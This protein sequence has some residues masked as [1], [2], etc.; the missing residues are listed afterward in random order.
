MQRRRR[1]A[2]R[3]LALTGAALIGLAAIVGLSVQCSPMGGAVP[4]L[5]DVGLELPELAKAAPVP[6]APPPALGKTLADVLA[7][8]AVCTT[9]AVRPLS[10]QIIAEANC[11]RPATYVHVDAGPRAT[12]GDAVFP[13]LVESARDALVGALAGKKRDRLTV[14]SMLRTVAQQ[15][16]LYGWY[17]AGRCG[18][19]LA[20]EPGRSNH[21]SGLAIDVSNPGAWRTALT[22]RG[23]RW[24]GKKDRWHFDF[25]GRKQAE[26][27]ATKRLAQELAGLDV[28]AFQ[29]L[30]NNN[31]GVPK[32]DETGELD[33][34]TREALAA[35]PTLGFAV[36]ASCAA[37]ASGPASPPAP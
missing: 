10:E 24:L 30:H 11:I 35:A 26:K 3:G 14:S 9:D 31:G 37:P 12:F 23:F 13:Y 8:D 36:G 15:Y 28:R 29:R 19:K 20:A 32:L 18:I 1:I 4:E 5:R 27:D 21:Q 22:A 17:Q 33:L 34:A 16:L 2:K 7:D 6:A 25:V